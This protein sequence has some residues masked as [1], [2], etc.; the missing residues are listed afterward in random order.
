MQENYSSNVLR[1]S[2]GHR[3]HQTFDRR[4]AIFSR[5]YGHTS[6]MQTL[7]YLFIQSEEVDELKSFFTVAKDH[8]AS[9][10]TEPNLISKD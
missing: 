5:A 4:K 8:C 2:W 1:K 3:Q 6:E 9:E 7:D 10:T